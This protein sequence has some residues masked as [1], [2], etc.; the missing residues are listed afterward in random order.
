MRQ[1]AEFTR[2]PDIVAFVKKLSQTAREQSL[3]L[4]RL[5]NI[6]DNLRQLEQKAVLFYPLIL[7]DRLELILAT[8]DSPPIR[9]SVPVKR[10]ELNRVI[11]QSRRSAL[12]E[13][14]SM[15]SQ[16]SDYL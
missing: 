13:L 12:T 9:R 11:L 15:R 6:S 2:R 16:K 14:L 4:K 1:F 10:E 7:E 8:P 5:R 3:S